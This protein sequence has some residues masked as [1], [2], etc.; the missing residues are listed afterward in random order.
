MEIINSKGS[1]IRRDVRF[2]V[3]DTGIGIEKSRLPKLFNLF[4]KNE[5]TNL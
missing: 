2:K 1:S 3:I 5:E 4:E